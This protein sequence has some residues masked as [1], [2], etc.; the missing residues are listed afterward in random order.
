MCHVH[1]HV[2]VLLRVFDLVEDLLGLSEMPQFS[3][4]Y[5]HNRR[6]LVVELVEA[7]DRL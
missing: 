4:N 1:K 2:D 3:H 5:G 6:R 7:E